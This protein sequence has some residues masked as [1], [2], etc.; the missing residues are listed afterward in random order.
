M[1]PLVSVFDTIMSVGLTW[2]STFVTGMLVRI[3][4]SLQKNSFGSRLMG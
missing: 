1:S 4:L 2:Y 3:A